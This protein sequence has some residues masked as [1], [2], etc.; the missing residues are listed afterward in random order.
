MRYL[1]AVAV[2]DTD[3]HRALLASVR[4]L[5]EESSA[6]R[7]RLLEAIAWPRDVEERFF[8]RGARELPA[9]TYVVDR[10]GHEA[11]IA[12]VKAALDAVDGD[13]P[14]AE[15]V[16]RCLQ[17]IID[18]NRLVLAVGTTE[19]YRLSREMYGGARTRFHGTGARNIDLAEHL[20]ERLRVHGWDE[21]EDP[22]P[23]VYS[24]A[25]FAAELER[26]AAAL[27]PG[28]ELEAR[29][30]DRVTAKV[31]AGSTRVRIRRGA[32]FTDWE[33]DGLWHHE[34]ETHVLSAQNGSL[35]PEVPFLRSG[36]PRST[37]AQEGLAV[38]SELHQHCLAAPRMERLAVR[39]Q[40]VE[41]AEA[42]ADFLEL[43]RF[44]RDR[45]SEA[46][47]AWLDA[48]RVCRGGR[49]EGG[50]PF[51]K[52]ASY[53]AGLLDVQAFLSVVARGG[54][55]DELELLVC[56]RID[57]DDLHALILLR[58]EGIL[59]RPRFLPT[60]LRRWSTFVTQFAFVSFAGELGNDALTARYAALVAEAASQRPPDTGEGSR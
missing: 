35:Q 15:W 24:D 47:D 40:L 34:V 42:G 39:V 48:Q 13:D 56:G 30:D 49:V 55:R 31:L 57:L 17:S 11:R 9:V 33:A 44:L 45:G 52:D 27:H 21:A 46:R 51:T 28:L 29:V 26:R 3:R 22:D 50:A 14:V 53:L 25:E 16:R 38:F 19:F 36:G 32:T 54:F 5:A 1:R 10:D 2:N 37:R 58:R 4:P 7:T 20:L 43:Y 8:A 18:A 12:E 6:R 60:W 23:R 59:Q 41:K